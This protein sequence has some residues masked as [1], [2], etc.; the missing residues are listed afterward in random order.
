MTNIQIIEGTNLMTVD[1]ETEHVGLPKE[2]IVDCKIIEILNHNGTKEDRKRAFEQ[3]DYKII[4][5][6]W[7]VKV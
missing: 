2:N 5:Y 1:T 7:T 6:R 4:G 3:N